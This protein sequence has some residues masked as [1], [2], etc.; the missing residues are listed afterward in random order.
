M[1]TTMR[2][3]TVG[4]VTLSIFAIIVCDNVAVSLLC[5]LSLFAL[6]MVWEI[7]K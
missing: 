7:A 2:M 1:R 3:M 4:A 6:G 5:G